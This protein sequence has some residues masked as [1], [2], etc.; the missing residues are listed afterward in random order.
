[1]RVD[2]GDAVAGKDVL[3]QHVPHERTL[4]RTARSEES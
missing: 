3:G 1:M 2:D 4:A